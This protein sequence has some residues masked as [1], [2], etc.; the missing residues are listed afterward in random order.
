M[1]ITLEKL[2]EL[3]ACK[4]GKEWFAAQK[5]SELRKAVGALMA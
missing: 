3:R 4:D 1:Q 2:K 5:E